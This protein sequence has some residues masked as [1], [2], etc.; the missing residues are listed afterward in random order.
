MNLIL[1]KKLQDMIALSC[2]TNHK[3]I[4][5]LAILQQVNAIYNDSSLKKLLI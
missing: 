3:I 5:G 4:K 1:D 2:W